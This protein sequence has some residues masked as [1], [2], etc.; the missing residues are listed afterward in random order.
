MWLGSLHPVSQEFR[1]SEALSFR[2]MSQATSVSQN[3]RPNPPPTSHASNL[4]LNEGRRLITIIWNQN[5]TGNLIFE[6]QWSLGWQIRGRDPMTD[7]TC[8]QNLRET[9]LM[10]RRL[11]EREAAAEASS[12][13]ISLTRECL[14]GLCG[15]EAFKA[16]GRIVEGW[17]VWRVTLI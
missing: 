1:V 8:Q 2:F 5:V 3:T 12:A 14:S 15:R 10:P 7:R 11:P 17:R 13:P 16:R 9:D 4:L 6:T